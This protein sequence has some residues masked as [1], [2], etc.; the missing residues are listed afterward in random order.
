VVDPGTDAKVGLQYAANHVLDARALQCQ[1]TT[2]CTAG[3]KTYE[4]K[5]L[6]TNGKNLFSVPVAA[7]ADHREEQ[8][9]EI[10]DAPL[11]R[12]RLYLWTDPDT[13]VTVTTFTKDA[14]GNISEDSTVTAIAKDIY[15]P[16]APPKP[17]L[18]QDAITEIE[19]EAWG[20]RDCRLAGIITLVALDEK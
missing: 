7:G 4:R 11:T 3:S 9:K 5:G 16:P 10:D 13:E 15:P 8:V 14:S 19:G 20:N 2:A 6:F 12:Q 1:K 18:M 17:E